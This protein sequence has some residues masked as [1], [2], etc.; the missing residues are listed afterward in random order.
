VGAACG[1]EER[2]RPLASPKRF[3]TPQDDP[4]HGKISE[5]QMN[6][7]VFEQMRIAYE[8]WLWLFR[9]PDLRK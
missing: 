6:L 2:C 7:R 5:R 9:K 8:T 3:H 1:I 4:E